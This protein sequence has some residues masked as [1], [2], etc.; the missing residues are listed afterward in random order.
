MLHPE[1]PRFLETPV[2]IRLLLNT[3]VVVLA[4]FASA[5]A[6]S[7]YNTSDTLK[8]LQTENVA[9][10]TEKRDRV[11]HFGSQGNGGSFS[12]H[13]SHSN[14]LIPVYTFG[15]KINLGAV[16]GK[17]SIYRD[18]SRL[19][20]LYGFAPVNTLNPEAE[21]A[22]QSDLYQVQ[23][24]AISKGVK[25]LFIVWFDGMDWVVTQAAAM[26][27][28]KKVYPSGKGSGLIFQDHDAQGSAV[29]LLRDRPDL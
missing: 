8:R 10:A 2:T 23:K 1:S 26:Y 28:S 18:A 15:R 19:T 14:R 4:T 7:P 27:R 6:Q 21:Y 24:D 20:A 22:D 13:T 17:N 3:S 5:C 11:Y 16:T 9:T 29:R 25:H 12:N